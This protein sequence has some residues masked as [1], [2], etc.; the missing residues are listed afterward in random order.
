MGKE[1]LH[2]KRERNLLRYVV[3]SRAVMIE[4]HMEEQDCDTQREVLL[5]GGAIRDTFKYQMSH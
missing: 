2:K 1:S 4:H 5:Y 3:G